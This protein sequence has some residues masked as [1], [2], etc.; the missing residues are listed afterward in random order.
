M[1]DISFTISQGQKIG[2]L[3][4][5]GSGKTT[6]IDSIVGL[7]PVESGKVYL[8]GLDI[9]L[10][11]IK[12]IRPVV[13]YI[14]QHVYLFS[15]SVAEN[16][17]MSLQFENSKVIETLKQVDL[18]ETFKLRDGTATQVG[19]SGVRLSG[20]QMH[21]IGIARALY[22]NAQI[23]IMDEPTASLDVS[24]AKVIL[25]ELVE[26][27]KGKTLIVISHQEEL[28]DMCDMI[29]KIENHRMVLAR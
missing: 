6:L 18:W 24:T 12:N 9:S 14:P 1:Q 4:K 28:L 17:A 21:R 3:G 23:I 19:E 15:G 22:R 11:S 8:N 29:Y 13:S 16:I 10:N 25:D 2:L 27:S 5:S 20:G 7:H 26:L